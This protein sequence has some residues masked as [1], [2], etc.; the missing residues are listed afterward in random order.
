MRCTIADH[1]PSH[2]KRTENL[3]IG[4]ISKLQ[5]R[6]AFRNSHEA[7]F[8]LIMKVFYVLSTRVCT[9]GG[10]HLIVQI[11][12]V[13]IITLR[14]FESYVYWKYSDNW[15][16]FYWARRHYKLNFRSFSPNPHPCRWFWELNI[17]LCSLTILDENIRQQLLGQRD[18]I[19]M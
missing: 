17:L 4:I 11:Y 18:V 13:L 14:Y 7:M 12:S 3:R 15:R 10:D 1:F 2:C 8:S 16:R 5:K 6:S 9:S 19:D